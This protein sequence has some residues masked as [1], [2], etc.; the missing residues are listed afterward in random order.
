MNVLRPMVRYIREYVSYQSLPRQLNFPG[1]FP[2][3]PSSFRNTSHAS[4]SELD[5][6][7]DTRKCARAVVRE[8][9]AGEGVRAEI[10]I[11]VCCKQRIC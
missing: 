5:F 7:L 8:V 11:A 10:F 3:F 2:L 9:Y 1:R 6:I 4:V